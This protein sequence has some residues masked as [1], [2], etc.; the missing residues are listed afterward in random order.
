[1]NP[2][3]LKTQATVAKKKKKSNIEVPEPLVPLHTDA[4]RIENEAI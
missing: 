1:M 2:M 3:D 4:E